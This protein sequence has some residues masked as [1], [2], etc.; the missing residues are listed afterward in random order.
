[1]RINTEMQIILDELHA[2]EGRAISKLIGI[3]VNDLGNGLIKHYYQ[4]QDIRTRQLIRAFLT[5]AGV[6]W[7][8]KLLT[9][10]VGAIATSKNKFASLSEYV[11]LLS[12]ND[13]AADFEAHIQA[14]S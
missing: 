3:S 6:V 9:N 10:D 1:M 4:T 11:Q 7:L 14:A 12:S 2:R 8:R 5:E 13:V